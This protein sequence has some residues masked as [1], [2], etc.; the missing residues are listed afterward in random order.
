MKSANE[1]VKI[2]LPKNQLELFGYDKYFNEF[3]KLSHEK[4]LPNRILLSGLKG[5]GKS[6]FLYHFINYLFSKDEDK[7]Y[8]K[9]DFT[10]DSNNKNYQNIINNVHPNF[11]LVENNQNEETIKIDKV[12]NILKF[13]NKSTYN[14]NT[15]IVMIDDAEYLNISSSNALLKSLEESNDNTFF[16]I[17][18]NSSKKISATIKSRCIEYKIFFNLDEKK[19]ILSKIMESH[20]IVFNYDNLDNNFFLEAPGFILKYL[21]IFNDINLE[22][23]KNKLSC[24]YYL[25]D[26]YKKKKDPQILNY[27]SLLVELFYSELSL[28]NSQNLNT[29]FYNKFKILSLLNNVKKFN[30]DKNNFCISLTGILNNE[31]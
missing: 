24:I 1:N 17:V 16:F 7:K 21:M 14:N 23:S 19:Y 13:L 6:T 11:Y 18:H 27:I 2:I 20:N 4:K 26:K 25:I 28:K 31:R 3:A 9:N 8:S 22:Y 12:K 30:L 10:I 29:Y 5:S 15:K